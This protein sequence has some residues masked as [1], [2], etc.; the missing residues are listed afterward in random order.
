MGK[1]RFGIL[2]FPTTPYEELAQLWRYIE[3]LGFASA[4]VADDLNIPGYS[5]FE[6][7]TL[8]GALARE[9][10]RLRIGTLVTATTFRHPAFLAAQVITVDHLSNG[11]TTL[12][13]GAGGPPNNYA[14]LGIA[15]W[16]AS[17]RRDRLEEQVVI[18]DQL[19]RGS[20]LTYDGQYYRTATAE[21]PQPIQQPR[22]PLVI[23]AHGPRGLS[24]AARFAD[25]WNSLGGQPYPDA[26]YGISVT[27]AEAVARTQQL[28]EQLD[29][30]CIE[31]GRNP[32]TISRSIAVYRPVS[33]DPLSSLAAFDD[34]VGR[35]A[36]IGIDEII[37][38]WPP[39]TNFL[40]RRPLSAEQQAIF[41][42]I[43]L[44]RFPKLQE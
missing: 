39:L 10:T 29:A 13:I 41:E 24:L 12:A 32:A 35:Y 34:Y 6:V 33:P 11:R 44:E 8:L 20:P 43:A 27:L 22:P 1:V 17:E 23:A 42:R 26:R 18:L 3:A 2:S 38:Y 37:F 15:P 36:E 5:D 21:M 25:G 19:L 28:S 9:T 16:S 14:S 31:I 4:W 40:E 7:W 30:Y